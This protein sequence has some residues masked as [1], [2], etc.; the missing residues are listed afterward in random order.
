MCKYVGAMIIGM[1]TYMLGFPIYDV[2]SNVFSLSNLLILV[3]FTTLWTI[4]II[5]VT[6]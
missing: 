5:E 2:D 4:L 3:G 6:K 1:L